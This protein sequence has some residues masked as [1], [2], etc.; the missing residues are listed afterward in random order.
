MELQDLVFAVLHLDCAVTQSFTASPVFLLFGRGMFVLCHCVLEACILFSIDQRFTVKRLFGNWKDCIY[1][2]DIVKYC[3]DVWNWTEYFFQYK[4]DL[5]GYTI[6]TCDRRLWVKIDVF[7]CQFDKSLSCDI[8]LDCQLDRIKNY[9][10]NKFPGISV[11][12]ILNLVN[13][14]GKTHPKCGQHYSQPEQ[15]RERKL[16]TNIH[17][18]LSFLTLDAIWLSQASFYHHNFLNHNGLGQNKPLLS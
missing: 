17:L 13:W 14:G 15:K 7:E 6:D 4:M 3:R 8:N 10:G 12:E 18:S 1:I 2:S 5:H 11:R 16:N 9:H